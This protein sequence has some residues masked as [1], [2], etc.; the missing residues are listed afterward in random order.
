MF[1][2]PN[3][4]KRATKLL[5][6][7]VVTL[8]LI[9]AAI[10]SISYAGSRSPIPDPGTLTVSAFRYPQF[11]SLPGASVA[12]FDT[13]GSE[14]ISGMTN[15]AGAVEFKLKQGAYHLVITAPKFERWQGSATI[16]G[17][18][19]TSVDALMWATA[20]LGTFTTLGR[21]GL[22]KAMLTG[23]RVT[24]HDLKGYE[25]A[26]GYT[27]AKG[28]F[29][30]KL[31][32]NSYVVAMEL[33]QYEGQKTE[34]VVKAGATL[35]HEALLMPLAPPPPMSGQLYV[36]VLD[37]SNKSPVY[38]AIVTLVDTG[39]TVVAKGATD[40]DGNVDF[41]LNFGTYLLVVKYEGYATWT[42]DVRIESATTK[43]AVSLSKDPVPAR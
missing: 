40:K 11:F 2:L 25:I 32:Q 7:A 14:V 37:D 35:F 3:T 1:S 8:A 19:Q 12:V 18:S 41:S 17:G 33:D 20:E 10:P 27:N 6:M 43:V 26:S 5:V 39:G 24:I 13:S 28:K 30:T 9:T 29:T 31:P 4:L 42:Q 23:V 22:T 38:D 15:Q 16:E 36:L 21:D 34:L